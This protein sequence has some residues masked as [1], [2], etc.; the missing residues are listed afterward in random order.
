[1]A[2]SVAKIRQFL[3]HDLW[4]IPAEF[5]PAEVLRRLIVTTRC[6]LQERMYFRA[7]ALTYSTLFATV[8]LLAIVFAIAK[9]FGL[10]A[11]VEQLIRDNLV[12]TPEVQDTV[13]GFV[14]SYL[15][16]SSGGIF[17]GFGVLL[18]LWTLFNLTS[19]IETTFNQIWQ[20]KSSRPLQRQ[21]TDYT[22]IIFLLPVFIVATTGLSIFI[23]NFLDSLGS[24]EVVI[25]P[26]VITLLKLSPWVLT[27]LFFTG[28]FMYIPNTRVAFRS[29]GLAGVITG[30][31]FQLM[32]WGYLNSQA[33]LTSY[34]AIYG[35]FAA[36]PLFLLMC[37][38]AWTLTLYG[39]T[40]AYVN[41]NFKSFYR[42]REN[43]SVSR[44]YHDYLCLRLTSSICR[45]FERKEAPLTAEELAEQHDVHIRL[46]TQILYTLCKV[47]ILVETNPEE[48]S[49]RATYVPA[50][51]INKLTAGEL[52]S[53]L[54]ADGNELFKADESTTWGTYCEER[55]RAHTDTFNG[56]PL[57]TLFPNADKEDKAKP[58]VRL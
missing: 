57:H 3:L 46:V 14:N 41:Q 32:Q 26:T 25:R 55:N 11:L 8:P 19:T 7:S 44:R 15:S 40:L 18:L 37:Q 23:Y 4:D 1:M 16:H 39:C 52:L 42:G 53:A 51:D 17:L 30:T 49:E 38:I 13:I 54:D 10:N 29:A 36:L 31:G 34:N 2:L 24:D 6:F 21:L 43:V 45:R 27:C 47:G 48:G 22:A 58:S 50:Y 20:V 5:L 12:A 33:W 35:S 28:L 9:G 56:Q